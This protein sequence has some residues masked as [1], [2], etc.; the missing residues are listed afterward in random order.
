MENRTPDTTHLGHRAR[1]KKRFSE[2]PDF[3]GFSQHEVLEM[4]LFFCYTRGDTNA[5][6]HRL[7][8]HFGSFDAVLSAEPEELLGSGIVGE[9]PAWA[10]S[11]LSSLC[12]YI[13]RGCDEDSI[14]A[15]DWDTVL[16]YITG[17][18][19]GEDKEVIKLFPVN[20]AMKL[21]RCLPLMTGGRHNIRF[22]TGEIAAKLLPT[23]CR[24]LFIAHNHPNASGKPSDSDV[25]STRMLMRGLNELGIK[26][27]D[28]I[29]VGNDGAYSLRRSGLL[30]DYEI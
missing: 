19:E 23:G 10:I 25:A 21:T 28:H 9:S 1:M 15:Y 2:N 27:I 24:T 7:I 14:T 11:F 4:L 12:A 17:W 13:R 29:V 30:F 26:L 5:I 20:D 22:D 16:E 18:F 3:A 6:A 8:E